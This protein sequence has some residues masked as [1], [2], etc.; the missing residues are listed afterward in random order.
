MRHALKSIPVV[1]AALVLAIQG[2]LGT[3]PVDSAEARQL[4]DVVPI[5]PDAD[6]NRTQPHVA[7]DSG[8]HRYLFVWPTTVRT[9]SVNTAEH[10]PTAG[11]TRTS[12]GTSLT[13]MAPSIRVLI[14]TSPLTRLLGRVIS[15]GP[16]FRSMSLEESTWLPGR[17][18]RLGP[19]REATAPTG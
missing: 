12:T 7:Y 16:M 11:P 19:M 10:H 3:L 15:S 18:S 8:N 17:R 2:W 13:E 5:N 14:Y 4:P 6:W 1:I 9:S